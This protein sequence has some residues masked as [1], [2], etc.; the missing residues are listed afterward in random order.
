MRQPN[1]PGGNSSQV[2]APLEEIG[3]NCNGTDRVTVDAASWDPAGMYLVLST[4]NQRK[5]QRNPIVSV[6]LE[7]TRDEQDPKMVSCTEL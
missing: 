5:F 6:K 3:C 2:F 4:Q 1:R 7:A